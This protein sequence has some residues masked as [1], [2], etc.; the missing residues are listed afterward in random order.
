[1][2]AA[3][4]LLLLAAAACAAARRLPL[5]APSD[6]CTKLALGYNVLLRTGSSA[7]SDKARSTR[8]W[9]GQGDLDEWLGG[10]LSSHHVTIA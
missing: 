5:A 7:G 10:G 6:S 1:M 8:G 2:R 4:L 9:L 3:P